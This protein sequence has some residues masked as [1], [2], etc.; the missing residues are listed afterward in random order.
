ME[1]RK[2]IN[3]V[4]T[5]SLFTLL[6]LSPAIDGLAQSQKR[7][8]AEGNAKD[9]R[10]IIS[11]SLGYVAWVKAEVRDRR[12]NEINNLTKDDFT[13]FEDGV[14]QSI[15]VWRSNE[16]TDGQSGQAMY[17]IGYYPT[18]F[19]FNGELRRIRVSVRGQVKRK[20]NV[21]ITPK[22]YYAKEELL[23]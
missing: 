7:S 21:Q 3:D 13:I 22:H 8:S 5:Q 14:K 4:L 6:F 15:C 9:D 10:Q 2:R 16:W 18:Q 1:N 23:K 17:V 19:E 12:G 20:L 11:C